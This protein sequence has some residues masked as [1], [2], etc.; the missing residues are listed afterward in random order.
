MR[1]KQ[2]NNSSTAIGLR[3]HYSTCKKGA[4]DLMIWNSPAS[5]YTIDVIL[6]PT[7]NNWTPGFRYIK[8]NE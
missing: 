3:N 1:K 6:V 4:L 5:V 8:E 2:K 7:P